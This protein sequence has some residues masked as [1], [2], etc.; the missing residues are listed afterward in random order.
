M[1]LA[2]NVKEGVSYW[3]KKGAE[4]K[5]VEIKPNERVVMMATNDNA[6]IPVQF[7]YEL[8]DVPVASATELQAQNMNSDVKG[9]VA[10]AGQKPGDLKARNTETHVPGATVGP[11]ASVAVAAPAA[12]PADSGAALKPPR[13]P[14]T[15]KK[16][17]EPLNEVH[18]ALIAEEQQA[19][20]IFKEIKAKRI[21]QEQIN[22]SLNSSICGIIG[23]DKKNKPLANAL[24]VGI[25][26]QEFNKLGG[27]TPMKTFAIIYRNAMEGLVQSRYQK[28][29]N[30]GLR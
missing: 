28:S 5:L 12:L 17:I 19:E 6:V 14:R 10:T 4:L 2:Q 9:V 1:V 22:A 16:T 30:N 18:A 3:S 23:I 13:K 7:N 21:R 27:K 20:A 8:S 25:T 24:R 15:T 26:L 29:L 11:K